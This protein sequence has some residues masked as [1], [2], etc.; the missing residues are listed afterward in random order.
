MKNLEPD[1]RFV[2]KWDPENSKRQEKKEERRKGRGSGS[3]GGARDQGP[4]GAGSRSG[5]YSSVTLY[6]EDGKHLSSGRDVCDCL[7]LDCP[8]CHFPCRKCANPKC[9][10]ECRCRRKHT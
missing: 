2:E 10:A 7:T 1:S 6:D 8:G 9:G 4:A 3:R 5:K